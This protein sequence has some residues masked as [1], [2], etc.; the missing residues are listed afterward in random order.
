MRSTLLLP[1][2]ALLTGCFDAVDGN[3]VPCESG[4]RQAWTNAISTPTGPLTVAT[5]QCVR[6]GWTYADCAAGQGP[7]H[8]VR[9]FAP[10]I[11]PVTPV[12]FLFGDI[13]FNQAIGHIVTSPPAILGGSITIEPGL[14][15]VREDAVAAGFRV[16]PV[17]TVTEIEGHPAWR[18]TVSCEHPD[19]DPICPFTWEYL[20]VDLSATFPE[21]Y[22]DLS[23]S[24]AAYVDASNTAQEWPE[25]FSHYDFMIDTLTMTIE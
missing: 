1:I 21:M 19:I 17:A 15:K 8:C 4:S 7:E 25:E 14:E 3:K 11:P 20:M 10:N 2:C 18:L 13:V 24:Y 22:A 5:E 9:F 16:S 6:S 12:T 23:I